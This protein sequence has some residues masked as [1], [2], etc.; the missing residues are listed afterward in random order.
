MRKSKTLND[1]VQLLSSDRKRLA[2]TNSFTRET[3]IHPASDRSNQVSIALGE[4]IVSICGLMMQA[5][6]LAIV[7]WAGGFCTPVA[8]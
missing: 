2:G 7:A 1:P 8:R 5:V 3:G 6:F 4:T